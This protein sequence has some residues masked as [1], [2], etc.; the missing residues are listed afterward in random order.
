MA[1]KTTDNK[2]KRN[3]S[4][5]TIRK[6]LFRIK[7]YWIFVAVSIIMATITVAS[8]LYVPILIGNAI[9]YIVGAGDVNFGEI[10]KILAK[11]GVVIGITALSQ[12]F[13]NICNN[14]ITF[15]VTRD[16]RDEAIEKIQHL[17]LKYIDAV[18]RC[19]NNSCGGAYHA[20][21]ISCG[22]IYC[23]E[24]IFDV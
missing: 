15:H 19:K 8:T 5:K 14:K 4:G 1:E 7:K 21:V 12:W 6:V 24:N 17:P 9:D 11:V 18:H 22:G 20:C 2:N 16:I 23:K 13:M 10:A 3:S